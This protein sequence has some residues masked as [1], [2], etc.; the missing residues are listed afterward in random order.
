MYTGGWEISMFID[1]LEPISILRKIVL[2]GLPYIPYYVK[3][4]F[5]QLS[6]LKGCLAAC[7]QSA[8]LMAWWSCVLGW[9]SQDHG[10]ENPC[11]HI[12]PHG[13]TN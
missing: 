1:P 2:T 9:E 6:S 4:L 5:Q 10:D 11:T 13:G 3:W 8:I 7:L 12:G